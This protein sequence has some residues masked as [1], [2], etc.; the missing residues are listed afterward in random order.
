MSAQ[1]LALLKI[2]LL[3]LL[4]LF[5]FRVVRAVWAELQ[6]PAPTS[7]GPTDE[8]RPP[9]PVA[10]GRRAPNVPVAEPPTGA[11]APLPPPMRPSPTPTQLV[12][13]APETLAGQAHPLGT[14]GA[15]IG[16][17]SACSV[18]FDD[19][20]VSTEHARVVPDSA[21]GWL[22]EDMGSTNGTWI[23]G[24]RIVGSHGVR[25]GDRLG[26]GGVVA[27]FR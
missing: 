3:V 13:V 19:A 2:S 24:Q 18:A 1:L 26:V 17:S 5:L 12:V 11:S 27:E 21:G 7:T 20:F 6:S 14:Q 10:A 25:S 9:V 23:N 15:T 16:R 22:V 8:L 4:Y